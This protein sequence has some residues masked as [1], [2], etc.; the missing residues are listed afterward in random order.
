MSDFVLVHGAWHGAWSWDAV[1]ERLRAAGHSVVTPDL[2]FIPGAVPA[3]GDVT[4]ASHIAGALEV[5]R[6]HGLTDFVLCGHSYGGMVATGIADAI[7]ECVRGVLFLD[8]YVPRDGDSVSSL[9]GGPADRDGLLSPPP[10]QALGLA[11]ESA[12]WVDARMTPQPAGTFAQP[13]VLRGAYTGPRTYVLATGWMSV[14]HFQAVARD[15]K[16]WPRWTVRELHGSH[17]LMIDRADAVCAMLLD[18]A[19]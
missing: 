7:P 2:A 6:S 10:A 3:S 17:D 5:I 19:G 12:A 11:G 9:S 15:A 13:I 18:A 16:G 1:T 14:P 4:L 8:A